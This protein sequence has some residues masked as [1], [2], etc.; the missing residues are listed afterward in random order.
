MDNKLNTLELFAGMGGLIDG[1]EQ[2][3][4][5]NLLAA[6][7]WAKPQVNT[8]I[9]RLLN[10]YNF[11]DAHQKVLHFDIQRTEELIEGWQN[12]D[13]YS[14]GIGLKH[15]IKNEKVDIIS[16]GPPCQAYSIAGRIR[17]KDGMKNDYRNFLFEAYIKI[18]DYFRPK[19][20][21]FENV[22]GILSAIP[23]GEKITDLIRESFNKA[24]YVI[25]DDLKKFALIDMSEYGVPQKRKRV[26]IIGI[27]K[28]F[29]M[30]Y[31]P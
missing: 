16:G 12:D 24:G 29:E 23:T 7:E 9:D 2:S 1:L 20:I 30:D 8:L 4:N 27:R 14:S 6:V 25:V 21:I 15:T 26:I 5:I 19:V 3:N 13:V 28:D 18:V 31:M 11:K 17:D 10:K 22:E